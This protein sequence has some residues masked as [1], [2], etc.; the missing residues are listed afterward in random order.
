MVRSR[1]RTVSTSVP[2]P[3]LVGVTELLLNAL[4]AP[5]SYFSEE[6]FYMNRKE[7]A[8]VS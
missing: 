1:E 4:S 8:L 5:F 2:D 3:V 7:R 6:G